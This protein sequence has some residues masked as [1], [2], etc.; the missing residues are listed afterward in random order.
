MYFLGNQMYHGSSP[1]TAMLISDAFHTLI[2][3]LGNSRN[4]V[5]GGHNVKTCDSHIS[6][7]ALRSYGK[8]PDFSHVCLGFL[9]TMAPF[10]KS[11]SH[12]EPYSQE[13]LVKNILNTYK[14]HDAKEDVSVL[15]KLVSSLK[16][17]DSDKLFASFPLSYTVQMH[18]YL[19]MVSSKLADTRKTD[20]QQKTV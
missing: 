11:H 12:L 6:V 10:S 17:S 7:N 13:A 5:L 19:Q 14:A 9:D 1:V 2:D 20:S 8:V 18:S 16:S 3:F 4:N 15:Q